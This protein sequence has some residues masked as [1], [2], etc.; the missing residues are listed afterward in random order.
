MQ[1]LAAQAA[2]GVTSVERNGHHYFRGLAQ[3]PAALQ[4][5]ALRWHPDLYARDEPGGWPRIRLREGRLK[6]GSVNAAPFGVPGEP[7]LSAV[8]AETVL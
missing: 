4:E 5:H 7:D 6:V 8:P 2:L 1:D 3:F